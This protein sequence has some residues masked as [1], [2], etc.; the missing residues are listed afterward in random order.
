MI[1]ISFPLWS[2][3]VLIVILHAHIKQYG[4]R[5]I[6]PD[7]SSPLLLLSWIL[8]GPDVLI[9]ALESCIEEWH[10]LTQPTYRDKTT[11]PIEWK[12]VPGFKIL[13]KSGFVFLTGIHPV[14]RPVHI[15]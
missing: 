12:V 11:G 10:Y 13:L 15:L 8:H 2:G 6:N 3:L 1:S 14:C 7:N 5:T 9:Q 4:H